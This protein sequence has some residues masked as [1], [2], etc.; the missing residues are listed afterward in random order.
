MSDFRPGAVAVARDAVFVS[1]KAGFVDAD[2]AA[3]AAGTPFLRK[4]A[5]QAAAD[6][7]DKEPPPGEPPAA[8]G[9][10]GGAVRSGREAEE[11]EEERELKRMEAASN[12]AAPKPGA[13]ELMHLKAADVSGLA[14]PGTDGR[15][16]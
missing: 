5:A 6:A 7:A 4:A 13:P 2:L 11:V 1:T 14:S 15:V 10:D 16:A 9:D 8:A 12:S 3:R